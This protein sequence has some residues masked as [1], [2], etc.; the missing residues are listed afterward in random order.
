MR[1]SRTDELRYPTV[2]YLFGNAVTS[3]L[4][5]MM[6]S[7]PVA[8]EKRST[9]RG[10]IIGARYR[11]ALKHLHKGHPHLGDGLEKPATYLTLSERYRHALKHLHKGHPHLGDG[12]EKPATYL[13]L[14]ERYRHALKHLHK[15]HP[16]LGDGLEKQ[17]AF[18]KRCE[19]D[20]TSVRS[21]M[22]LYQ[23]SITHTASFNARTHS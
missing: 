20:C 2:R 4:F 14:S 18:L 11:H 21:W 15:G 17:T 22:C 19:R 12:L 3:H 23:S 10:R 9:W 1:P 8:W 6:M 7:D 13:T 5:V 16:H